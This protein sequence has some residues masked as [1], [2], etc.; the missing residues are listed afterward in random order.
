MANLVRWQ[1]RGRYL[2][3]ETVRIVIVDYLF[4]TISDYAGGSISILW[5]FVLSLFCL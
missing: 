2:I 4:Y 1:S 5:D 3:L